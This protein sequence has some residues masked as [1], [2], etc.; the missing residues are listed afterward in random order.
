M[1]GKARPSDGFWAGV[2][3]GAATT[4]VVVMDGERAIRGSHVQRS[5]VDYDAGSQ[6]AFR[7]AVE[8]AGIS[9]GKVKGVVS[10]GYGRHNVSFSQ[11]TKTEIGCHMKGCFHHY[12]HA[13]TIVDI[14]GQD[15]K[16][17]HVDEKGRRSG[18]RMNRKCAAG[19]GAFLEEIALRLGLDISDLD[20]MARRATKE[21][22]I[23]A[24]CTVFSSTEI[25]T[26]IRKGERVED[27]ARGVFDSVVQRLLEMDTLSGTVLLTGGVIQHNPILADILR[28]QLAREVIVPPDPQLMGA[29]GAAL[30]ALE[31]AQGRCDREQ[32]EA[33]DVG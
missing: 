2:D 10:T 30:Y 7:Q 24:Y 18:F 20:Q 33:M 16:V 11:E 8:R 3:V 14:G 6:A 32:K 19:T 28:G 29:F 12:P 31:A 4:K 17:I 25:L 21:V 1:K 13:A 23:G 15:A 26:L 22:R 27:I 5:G 9:V